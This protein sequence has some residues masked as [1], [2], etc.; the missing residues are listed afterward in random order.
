MKK[1]KI[2]LAALGLLSLVCVLLTGCGE[3]LMQAEVNTD[4]P[5][6]ES[7]LEVGSAQITVKLYSMEIYLGEDYVLS[8]PLTGLTLRINDL[9]LQ[10]NAKGSYSASLG[11]D[12]IRSGQ[13]YRLQF[14]YAG[15]TVQA[16]TLIPAPVT[17]LKIEPASVKRTSS[18]YLW[19]MEGDTT[20]VILSWDNPDN[21]YYQIYVDASNTASDFFDSNFRKRMMQPIQAGSYALTMQEFRS[22]GS[23]YIYAY[24]VNKE[25]VDLYERISSTDLANPVSYI[26]NAFGIFTS[27]S[28]ARVSFQVIES[29]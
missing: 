28:V 19:G 29:E 1:K 12:T 5:V 10:E 23:Y 14:D 8:K 18:S 4:M 26:E 9:E 2:Y 27:M 22:A 24:R 17:Q 15:K 6:V 11:A 13:E 21:S 3:T 16:T 25:Y 7:Y 20:K